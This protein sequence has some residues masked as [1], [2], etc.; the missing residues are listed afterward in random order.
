[1][2]APLQDTRGHGPF[3]SEAS[4]RQRLARLY[5]NDV[6]AYRREL[7][8]CRR[9]L[10]RHSIHELRIAIRRLLVCLRLLG[11]AQGEPPGARAL[12]QRELKSLG[13]VRDAQVQ[14][15]LV[16]KGPSRGAAALEPLREHLRRRKR[17]RAKVAGL[18]L[19]SDKALRRLQGWSP[20]LAGKVPGIIPRLRRLIDGRLHEAIDSLSSFSGS[21]SAGC[22]A[23][24][25]TRVLSRECCYIVDALRPCWRGDRTD[26]LLSMLRGRQQCV[27][28]IHDRELLLRRIGR[29]VAHGSLDAESARTLCAV[30]RSERARRMKSCSRRDWRRVLEALLGRREPGGAGRGDSHP[31]AIGGKAGGCLW[32]AALPR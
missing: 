16:G 14:L 13:E 30:L 17:R 26:T 22:A 10:S 18:A 23:R 5:R 6:R 28:Q 24:H 4:V 31:A 9:R 21:A 19:D 20:R 25:R 2:R 27:G 15:Q 1:M 32:T 29:L 3:S 11:A 7:T 12:L 8:A